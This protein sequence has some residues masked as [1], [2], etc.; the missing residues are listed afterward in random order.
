MRLRKWR[1]LA[2]TQRIIHDSSNTRSGKITAFVLLL[3]LLPLLI[4]LLRLLLQTSFSRTRT[5]DAILS[6]YYNNATGCLAGCTQ[7]D[8][9]F[10]LHYNLANT[11]EMQRRVVAAMQRSVEKAN[12]HFSTGRL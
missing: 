9:A 10:F 1:L 12:Y 4:L 5:R 2:V 8:Q 7:A 3:L 11:Q 6:T